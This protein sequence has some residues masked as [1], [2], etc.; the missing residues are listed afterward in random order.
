[1]LNNSIDPSTLEIRSADGHTAVI[2]ETNTAQTGPNRAARK[3]ELVFNKIGDKYF[4]SN[5]WLEGRYLGNELER[6]KA[7]KKLEAGARR[8]CWTS[9]LETPIQRT[10][11][12]RW[13]SAIVAHPSSRSVPLSSGGQ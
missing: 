10:L 4:L 2:F 7:E 12:S 5:I 1:M 8:I 11:P 9:K 6:T 13:S 3:T